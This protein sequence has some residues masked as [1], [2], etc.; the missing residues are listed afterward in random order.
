MSTVDLSGLDRLLKH[1]RRVQHPQ[2]VLLQATT[3]QVMKD[4]NRKG[5]LA[6]TDK[7]GAYMLAV[8]YRPKGAKGRTANARQ[9][10][11]VKGRRGVFSGLGPAAA[12]LHNNLTSGEY[13]KLS[14]PPLAP[15]GAFSRVITNYQTTPFID[16]PLRFGV[17]GL[18]L[19]V[20]NAKGRTFLSHHFNGAG[21]LP[22]RDLRGIR[23][24]GRAKLRRAFIA[25][26]ADQIR[27]RG[28]VA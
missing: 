4:D 28:K 16:G 3:I 9:R 21:R 22:K 14:G 15:R 12:G 8:T 17:I 24:D 18:W 11:N 2:P 1:L 19:D 6:G 5:I 27:Y 13:R 7:D 20:V 26:A 10:N 25:W 23:P